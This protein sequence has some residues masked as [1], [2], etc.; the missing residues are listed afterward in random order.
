MGRSGSGVEARDS[1][2]RIKFVLNGETIRERVTI[3]GKSLD[4]TPANRKYA[5]RLAAEIKRRIDLGNFSFAEFFPDSARARTEKHEATT[6]DKLADLW[7]ESCGRLSDASQSQYAS[8]VRLWKRLLGEKTLIR[9]ITHKTLASKIGAHPWS[10]AKTHNNYLI[11]LRGIFNLEY[12]GPAT[13]HNPMNG[14]KDMKVV[15]TLPDPLSASERDAILGD[16]KT[17]YDE[18]VHAYF[19]SL[20]SG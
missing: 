1:S 20:L 17:Q 8:A 4:P 16:M 6:F 18:R 19:Q 15:R 9:D 5:E 12:P 10:T 13:I 11:A 2:I 7:L 14:I 3:N